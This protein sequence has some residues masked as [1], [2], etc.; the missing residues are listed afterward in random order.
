M[1]PE[2]SCAEPQFDRIGTLPA[3]SGVDVIDCEDGWCA[4]TKA[5]EEV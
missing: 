5:V 4:P 2:P 3:D 1:I